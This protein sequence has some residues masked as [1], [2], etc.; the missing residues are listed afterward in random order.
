MKLEKLNPWNWFKHEESHA[1]QEPLPVRREDATSLHSAPIMRLQ[2][3]FDQ[4]F[5]QAFQALGLPAF[6]SSSVAG[7]MDFRPSVDI[8]GS[9]H[10]YEIALDVPGMA[11]E[12]IDIEV[13]GDRLLI[14]GRKE[15]TR[16]NK[17]AQYYRIERSY[18]AFQRTLAL[19]DDANVDDITAELKDGVLRLRIARKALPRSESKRIEI[20]S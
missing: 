4:L 12:D 19:P 11:R 10:N 13:R 9:E 16:E 2:R 8:S 17:E 7:R 20:H 6:K 18:G 3:E 14:Q 5:E 1:Q 15:A